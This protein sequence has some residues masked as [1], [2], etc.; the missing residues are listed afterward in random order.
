MKKNKNIF[1]DKKTKLMFFTLILSIILLIGVTFSWFISIIELPQNEIKTG[2]LEYVVKGYDANGNFISNIMLPEDINDDTINANT[3]I[4]DLEDIRVGSYTTA[5]I[6]IEKSGSLDMDYSLKFNVN[7]PEEDMKNIG[8]FWYRVVKLENLNYSNISDINDNKPNDEGY[9]PKTVEYSSI[10]SEYASSYGKIIECS[11]NC[12]KN[13]SEGSCTEHS[14]ETRNLITLNH[15]DQRGTLTN[16]KRVDIYRID[17][18]LR[19]IAIEDRYTGLKLKISGQVYGTQIGAIDNEEGVGTV[20][21]VSDTHSLNL[22]IQN[23]LPGDTI[24]LTGSI[25]YHGDL[26]FNK[27]INIDT[28]GKDL[29]V[30]GNLIFDF[31]S[32]YSLKLNLSHGGSIKVLKENDAGGDFEINAPNSEVQIIGS[33][34]TT[35]ISVEDEAKFNVT[36]RKDTEGLLLNGAN[37][38][39]KDGAPKDID[40]DSDSKITLSSGATIDRIEALP[41]S[42]NIEIINYGT[43]KIIHL[44]KMKLIDEYPDDLVDTEYPQ[45]IINNYSKILTPIQLPNWSTAYITE[46]NEDGKYEG[47]TIIYRQIGAYEMSVYED[48]GCDYK[49]GDIIDYNRQ[50]VCVVQKVSG[51][52][53]SLIVYYGNRLREDNSIEVT[54]LKDLLIEYFKKYYNNTISDEVAALYLH[55]ITELKIVS[56]VDIASFEGYSKEVTYDDIDDMNDKTIMSR[57]SSIDLSNAVIENNTIPANAFNGKVELKTVLLPNTLTT[58]QNNAFANTGMIQIRVPASVTSYT[59]TAFTGMRFIFLDSLTPSYSAGGNNTLHY[60]VNEASF[61]AY[62]NGYWKTW[63]S[64]YQFNYTSKIH[65]DGVVTDDGMHVVRNKS[66]GYE[67]IYYAGDVETE[68]LR[69]G[70]DLTL[71]GEAIKITNIREYCFTEISKPF[72]ANF[73]SSITSIGDKAFIISKV[74][75]IKFNN[76]RYIGKSAFYRCDNITELEFENVE[77]ID[78]MAFGWCKNLFK[79]NCPN[80]LTIKT[81]AFNWNTSLSEMTFDKIQLIETNGFNNKNGGY[82]SHSYVRVYFNNDSF[83]GCSYA[84]LTRTDNALLKVFV[85]PELVESFRKTGFVAASLVYPMGDIVGEYYYELT[86]TVADESVLLGRINLGEYVVSK[87]DNNVKLICYNIP[88]IIEDFEVPG[89]ATLK[90]GGK[91]KIKTITSVG[92]Y[93]F[94]RIKFEAVKLTFPDSIELLDDY[95]FYNVTSTGYYVKIKNIDFGGVKS[96]GAY[97]FD[98]LEYL[99]LINEDNIIET[100]G[101]YAFRGCTSLFYATFDNIKVLGS[102]SV[103]ENGIFS[104]CTGMVSLKFGPNLVSI[105]GT[106]LISTTCTM[107]EEIIFESEITSENYKSGFIPTKDMKNT[108]LRIYVPYTVINQ[109]LSTYSSYLRETGVRYGSYLVYDKIGNNSFNLGEYIV[110]EANIEGTVGINICSYNVENADSAINHVVPIN[111]NGKNVIRF[112]FNSFRNAPIG[113]FK[114]DEEHGE[115]IAI[116]EFLLEIASYSFYETAVRI[117]ELPKVKYIGDYAFYN[118]DNLYIINAPELLE[119]GNGTFENCNQLISFKAVKLVKV[120]ITFFNSS[121]PLEILTN[122]QEV[123]DID[124][125]TS[126]NFSYIT[127]AMDDGST[128]KVANGKTFST[129]ITSRALV[130]NHELAMKYTKN[131]GYSS[132]YGIFSKEL[133]KLT[134]LYEK[135]IVDVDGKVIYKIE[136][137]EYLINNDGDATIYRGLVKTYTEDYYV[138]TILDGRTV[139]S[140]GEYAF[141]FNNFNYNRIIFGN[142][143]TKVGNG[144]FRSSKISGVLHLNNITSVGANCFEGNDIISIIAPKVTSVSNASF[145]S[146]ANLTSVYFGSLTT[147]N[148]IILSGCNK[149]TYIYTEAFLVM[150]VA[151]VFAKKTDITVVMNIEVVDA[152]DIETKNWNLFSNVTMYVPYNSLEIYESVF[153]NNSTYVNF[154]VEPFGIIY[155]NEETGD[156]F[157][158][159]EKQGEYVYEEETQTGYY[160]TVYELSSCLSSNLSVVI[161][162]THNG[163]KITSIYKDAFISSENLYVLTLPRYLRTYDE[164]AFVN[165]KQLGFLY[166]SE[167]NEY[168]KSIDGVLYSKDGLELICYPKGRPGT[169]YTVEENTKVIRSNAFFDCA[170]LNTIIIPESITVIGYNAFVGTNLQSVTF[171]SETAPFVTG[172]EIFDTTVVSPTIYVPKNCASTYK[173]INAFAYLNIIEKE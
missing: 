86:G 144:A 142:T 23:S 129:V 76:I 54:T 12:P 71:N 105:Y 100:L 34:Y 26:I 92:K 96:V 58:I 148:N 49:S 118:C 109:Q 102:E 91:E 79:I 167:D 27:C 22:A 173:K 99:E 56:L 126:S 28:Y 110:R 2:T 61:D 81:D 143:I 125:I 84:A 160:E 88:N 145:S 55:D 77:V 104:G 169:S 106:N 64:D 29:I 5:Y 37:I 46:P 40:V 50:D 78:T 65:V 85:K 20:H 48:Q 36:N 73:E 44:G 87:D 52:N 135:E 161:P 39:N 60:F 138:P 32:N 31:V 24:L 6:S 11:D 43:I 163:I 75:G 130:I 156:T 140:V 121:K 117:S 120:G 101:Q 124:W 7:G 45:I 149:L 94:H 10:I 25:A 17:I 90:Y 57:L 18:G 72:I 93:A 133:V 122:I 103:T 98:K 132:T 141:Y 19:S 131:V 35:N 123:G 137:H 116:S 165:A 107:L 164:M 150:E 67:L 158:F 9:D 33:N 108:T 66:N 1:K 47:N 153:E 59:H 168:Y 113:S 147:I 42:S 38:L 97:C 139:T 119:A 128:I 21:R 170:M 171:M 89:T 95:I 4:F 69:I 159:Q 152:N 30:Y 15:F 157:I 8:G 63:T 136:L 112:G 146:N 13:G 53:D 127:A 111:I 166:I 134:G 3:P 115:N 83:D 155:N 151:T 16:N 41:N 172:S 80:V 82:Y 154:K 14:L 74:R 70:Y 162:D 114:T 68:E 62:V 51:K